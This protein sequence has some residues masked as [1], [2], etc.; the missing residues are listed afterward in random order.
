[1]KRGY[2]IIL[3]LGIVLASLVAAGV[4]AMAILGI[5]EDPPDD[6][7]MQVTWADIPE[8]DNAFTY[9]NQA[10]QK[11]Y[12]PDE[13]RTKPLLGMLSGETWDDAL[14]KEVLER[15]SETLA[16]FEKGMAR[17]QFQFPDQRK[18]SLQMVPW[19]KIT[20]L[21]S[22]RAAATY[23]AGRHEQAF[24]EALQLVRFGYLCENGRGGLTGNLIG[25]GARVLGTRLIQRMLPQTNLGA[26]KL[27]RIAA[28]L[29]ACSA[30]GKGMAD[31]MRIEYLCV[32]YR[33]ETIFGELVSR[34]APS[35]ANLAYPRQFL[36]SRFVYKPNETKRML[37]ESLRVEVQNATKVYMQIHHPALRFGPQEGES[38]WWYVAKRCASGNG[39]GKLLSGLPAPALVPQI[40]GACMDRVP[41]RATSVLVALKACKAKTGRLPQSLAELVPEYLAAVPVDDMDGK[42]LRYS[43]EK[44][45][46]YSVGKDLADDG[47]SKDKDI[48]FEIEF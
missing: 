39:I 5:D 42:P 7:D 33:Q 29:A 2:R 41:T 24:D 6:S 46:V 48:V 13:N 3:K 18:S 4:V 26:E 34:R 35:P 16:L 8:A 28:Q 43:P 45:V 20:Q 23:R 47:G 40:D 27:Q 32:I 1:M 25:I 31:A 30:D 37:L 9:F 36:W 17:P 10:A 19:V 22:V 38:S 44:K 11:L 21:A 14:A 12:W 15:N